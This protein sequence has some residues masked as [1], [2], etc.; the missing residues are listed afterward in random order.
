VNDKIAV[1]TAVNIRVLHCLKTTSVKYLNTNNTSIV[2]KLEYNNFSTLF[3]GDI[4]APIE[5]NLVDSDSVS[6]KEVVLKAPHHGSSTS[7]SID[8]LK[9]VAPQFTVISVGQNNRY[10]HPS[11]TVLN[12]YKEFS[13]MKLFRTDQQGTIEMLT[14]GKEL[15]VKLQVPV[16]FEKLYKF[17]RY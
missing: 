1:D 9:A 12:R 17:F 5:K 15:K 13:D 4:E 10:N 7:N 3:T 6:L 14:D 11:Q 8:F 2:L 16:D